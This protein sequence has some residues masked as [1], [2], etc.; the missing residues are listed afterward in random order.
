[1]DKIFVLAA[2]SPP[3]PGPDWLASLPPER[4]AR[5]SPSMPPS[6]VA[7]IV[8]AYR[9]LACGLREFFG[10]A[11]TPRI[12]LDENGKPF[13]PGEGHPHFSLSHTRGGALCAL[14]SRPV[15]ADMERARAVNGRLF[16]RICGGAPYDEENFFKEWTA[17]EAA[18]KLSGRGSLLTPPTVPEGFALTHFV[19]RGFYMCVCGQGVAEEPLWVDDM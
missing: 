3:L 11:Q 14:S 7:E 17:R 19:R 13:F 4:G 16:V 15:G 12:A 9:L 18:L 6:K 2:L 1:M 10:I 5:L 8:T